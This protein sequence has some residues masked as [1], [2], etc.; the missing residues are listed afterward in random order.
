MAVEVAT[1]ATAFGDVLRR[2]RLTAGLTQ[3]DL[4][5]LGIKLTITKFD[6]AAWLDQVNNRK[7]KGFWQSSDPAIATVENGLVR[8][9]G[10]TTSTCQVT[11]T[12]RSGKLTATKLVVVE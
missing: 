10:C 11:I 3:A 1:E 2:L 8:A 9:V 6:Q 5:R 12:A 7:Y 4:A